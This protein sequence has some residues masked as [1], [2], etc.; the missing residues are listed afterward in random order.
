MKKLCTLWLTLIPWLTYGQS[1]SAPF[2]F[3]YSQQPTVSVDGR[4]LLNPWAGGLNAMQFATL[5]LN[6]DARD[7]L[8]VYDRTSRKV[9]TFVAVDNPTGT[10]IAWQYA[11]TYETMLPPL[12]GWVVAVDYDGDGKKDLFSLIN[13]NVRVYHNDS[14]GGKVAFSVAVDPLMTQGFA[15]RQILYVSPADSPA[16]LDYD[17]DGDIDILTFDPTGNLIAYQQN[18]SVERTGKKDGLD[19]KRPDCFYWGHFLKEFCNDFVFN[20]NCDGTTGQSVPLRPKTGAARPMHSGNTLAVLDTDG[21]GKKDLLFGS[22][23]C[24]GVARLVNVA[25]NDSSARFTRFDT[26]FPAK[27]PVLFPAFAGVY[28]EDADGDG[29]R[30]LLASTF[31]DVNENDAYDFRASGWFYRNAGTNAK[32]DF[33]LKQKDFLQ[34]DML[35]LGENAVPA[36]ADLDG[37]GDMDLLVGYAGV[38]TGKGYRSGIWQFENKGTLQNPAFSLVTTDYLGMAQSLT[39]TNTMPTFADVD[40]NGSTD[41]IVTGTG[42]SSL[43]I[44]LFLNAAAKGAPVQYTLTTAVR[45]P[46][47]DLM[48]LGE[49]LTVTDLD[50][51]GKADVLLGKNNGLIHYFR[52][53]GT[54]TNP[55]FQLQ[56]QN[57]GNLPTTYTYSGAYS[58]VLA[59]LNGDQQN[60]FVMASG[61]GRIKLYQFPDQ[62]TGSLTLLDS[63]PALGLPGSKLAASMADLDGDG[64]P[65]LMLGTGAGGLRYLKNVSQKKLVTGLPTETTGPWAFPNPTDRYLIV[66]APHDG[67]VDMLS[68]SGQTVLAGQAVKANTEQTLDL[69]SLAEGTYLLRLTA[70]GKTAQV[71]KIVIWK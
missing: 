14:Q 68:L 61:D 56:N 21:D 34:S 13:G 58:L 64:L 55:V 4:A 32:P 23:S 8:L 12:S 65:D 33:Q 67:Q 27:N 28:L 69:G 36:L 57:F 71:E 2:G 54:A 53:T 15:G 47:P 16:I 1:S 49:R 5:R 45:W 11:P 46:N 52:N 25:T 59:D 7:D 48:Q 3:Q 37:D 31:T 39:L 9:S 51:D 30:D 70:P 66:R 24:P 44:R 20:I 42:T 41:L 18:M 60:E 40:G 63:L 35:D 50:R 38:Q 62:L 19:F 10:G 43:E 22:V 6:D 29:V 26:L 17:D